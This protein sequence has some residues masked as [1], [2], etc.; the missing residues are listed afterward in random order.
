M[1]KIHKQLL[2]PFSA[3]QMYDLVNDI[4]AYPEFLPWC[5]SATVHNRNDSELKATLCLSKGPLKHNITTKNNMRKGLQINMD[6]S[7]GPFKNCIGSWHFNE[8]ANGHCQ[9]IFNFEYEFAN[10]LT[11]F[12]IEPIF[13]P[14]S[15][16]LVE[17]FYKRALQVYG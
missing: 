10:R 15:N 12:A 17:A 14:I 11:A 8:Q 2:V 13:F 6:Y 3:Q 1:A 16:T 5:K 4:E 7:A 9:V